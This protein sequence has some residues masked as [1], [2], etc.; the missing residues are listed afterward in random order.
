M[1]NFENSVAEVSAGEHGER[2]GGNSDELTLDKNKLRN[3]TLS[4]FVIN[5]HDR[6]MSES[7]MNS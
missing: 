7:R 6:V 2:Q 1:N 5:R 4:G 3:M